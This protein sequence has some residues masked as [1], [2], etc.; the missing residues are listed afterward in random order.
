MSFGRKEKPVSEVARWSG[1]GRYLPARKCCEERFWFL[2]SLEG[3][4]EEC[5]RRNLLDAP[6]PVFPV[7][8]ADQP[9]Q[10]VDIAS[11]D[12]ERF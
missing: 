10:I 3:N 12:A 9:V 2:D 5:L 11:L 7:A 4:V 8:R 1:N 6:S